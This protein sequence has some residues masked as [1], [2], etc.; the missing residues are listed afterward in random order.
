[1]LTTLLFSVA[2][3]LLLASIKVNSHLKQEL[4]VKT[5]QLAKTIN[6]YKQVVVHMSE[7][8]LKDALPSNGTQKLTRR[9]ASGRL[10]IFDNE[11]EKFAA[12]QSKQVKSR[13][14]PS[15]S[16]NHG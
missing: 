13:P 14:R 10:S 2:S 16:E 7:L 12:I 4:H 8:E 9:K 15:A 1:M 6:A 11:D 5:E 3:L